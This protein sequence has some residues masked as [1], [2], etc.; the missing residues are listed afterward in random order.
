MVAGLSRKKKS[1]AAFADQLSEVLAEFRTASKEFAEA[2]DRDA[3]SFDSVMAAYKL[4]NTNPDELTRRQSAIRQA[5]L[6]AAEV[7]LQVARKA[8][9]IYERLGQLER[10]SSAS[11]LSDVH[12]ARLMAVAA[13]RGALE[14]V[15]INLES[16]IE[17]G[18]D[19]KIVAQLR[20]DTAALESRVSESSVVAGEL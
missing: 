2:I 16:M 7:P 14:N 19:A 5:L 15:S 12:V 4:P 20:L 11:M 17:A 8:V 10:L 1:Q 3:A 6:F 13:A 9:V 18:A